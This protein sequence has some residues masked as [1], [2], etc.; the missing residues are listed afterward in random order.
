MV[1]AL[2]ARSAGADLAVEEI[3]LPRPEPGEVRVRI[4]A[5][6]VCHSD[7]SMINGTVRPKFP[8]V[9]GHEAA[10]VVIETGSEVRR[11]AEGDHVVINWSPACGECAFCQ[12]GEPWLCVTMEGV[13]SRP[14][15]TL[16]DGTPTHVTLGVGALAE[17]VVVSEGALVTVSP[18]LPMADAAL[19]GCAV[20][21]GVGAVHNT[22]RV[23][24]GESVAVI[25]LGGVGLS[26]VAGA[27]LAGAERIVAVDISA[28]KEE[29]A[30]TCGATDFLISNPELPQVV[31]SLTDGLGVN[32]T[33]ECVGRSDTIRA[34][35][36]ST[37]RG[38]TCVVVGMGSRDD[39]IS[40]SAL[41][42]FHFARTLTSSVYGSADPDRD[43]PGIASAV[44]SGSLNLDA[45]VTHQISLSDVPAAFDRMRH[46]EGGRSIV[47]FT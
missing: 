45:I 30:R 4:A 43:I 8:L 44:L 12:H 47:L 1:K 28:D 11:V 38:G 26:A 21:T 42:L 40:F 15:G 10:G 25:G 33:F 20:L 37:R 5:A 3:E 39:K 36:Q 2:V 22:A 41:E 9:L 16:A 32:H 31:H 24:Q 13:T 35:W 27:Q 29:L 46:G 34:A 6:G 19:L 18:E 7:L 14:R 23:R 17:E